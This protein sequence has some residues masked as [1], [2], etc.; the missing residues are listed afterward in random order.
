MKNVNIDDLTRKALARSYYTL[1]EDTITLID[2]ANAIQVFIADN[3][4]HDPE[5]ARLLD[6]YD[7]IVDSIDI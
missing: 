4:E 1:K 3:Y 5:L 6:Y 2:A 7:N